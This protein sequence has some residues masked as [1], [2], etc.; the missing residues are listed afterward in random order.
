MAYVK[1]NNRP[2]DKTVNSFVDELFGSIPHL[3]NE[4]PNSFPK[5]GHVPVNI[6]ESDTGYLLELIAPGFN[7]AD[8]KINLVATIL[9][10]SAEKEKEEKSETENKQIEKQIKKEYDFRSFKRSFTIDD[11]I[12]ATGI[13]ASYVN[14]VMILNLP[15]RKEVREAAKEI[16]IK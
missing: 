16:I 5:Y 12:D 7:K 15:K 11:K 4:Y 1:I 8:F 6:K 13:E 2:F 3:F 10:I 9:T 14:G